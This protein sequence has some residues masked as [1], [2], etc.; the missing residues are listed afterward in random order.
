MFSKQ[1]TGEFVDV[2]T[3]HLGI[4]EDLDEDDDLSKYADWEQDGIK[5]ALEILENWS[6]HKRLPTQ[7]DIHEYNIG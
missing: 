1:N 2:Q 3:E 6:S 5:Q 7:Y 4:A